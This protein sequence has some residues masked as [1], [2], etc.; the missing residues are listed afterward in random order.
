MLVYRITLAQF[1][2][3]L[4][5]PGTEGR[6]NSKGKHVIYTAGSRA[7]ACLENL[8]HRDSEG[9]KN[10]FKVI[11]I[12][13]P[14]KV[15]IIEIQD[16][17]L[18]ISWTKAENFYITRKIGNNWLLSLSSC[19]LKVLSAIIIN[20]NNFLINPYHPDFTKISVKEIE[21]FEF[22]SRMKS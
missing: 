2:N 5:A 18:P 12:D 6:W 8:V 1:A 9:L 20:E 17:D 19:I 14:S 11:A 16:H 21:P 4:T 13:I 15:S 7:L 10:L 3:Q 22:D